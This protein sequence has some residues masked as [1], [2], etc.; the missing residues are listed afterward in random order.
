MN[1]FIVDAGSNMLPAFVEYSVSPRVSETIMAPHV[2][3]R[4]RA[5]RNVPMSAASASAETGEVYRS[6][7]G[8]VRRAVGR[9]VALAFELLVDAGRVVAFFALLLGLAAVPGLP[10]CAVE[11]AAGTASSEATA[12]TLKTRGTSRVEM[13]REVITMFDLATGVPGTAKSAGLAVTRPTRYAA[14]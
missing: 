4:V 11:L 3:L 5:F 2:P 8:G 12:R 9:R 6:A 14:T 10:F 7:G 13:R 1:N